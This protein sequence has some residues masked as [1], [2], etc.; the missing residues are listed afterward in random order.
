MAV[1]KLVDSTQLD[2]DLTSVANAIRTKGGTSA[3]LAFPADFVQAIEDIETGGGGD[4]VANDWLD[5]TKPV[6]E[7]SSDATNISYYTFNGHT[8]ITKVSVP[9]AT[10]IPNSCFKDCTLLEEVIAPNVTNVEGSA[11]KGTTAINKPLFFPKAYVWTD[12][13][14]GSSAPIIVCNRIINSNS[15][16]F[17]DNSSLMAVDFLGTA[18][19]NFNGNTLFANCSS[20]KTLILRDS[21]MLTLSNINSFDSTPFANGGSGGTL[22]VPQALI[23]EY[24]AATNWSTLLSYANNQILPIAVAHQL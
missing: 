21:T 2:A 19:Q 14:R 16:I 20:F 3:Q 13:F 24:Q 9:N 7:I 4:Y 22:Y 10:S 5:R 18:H 15:S 11:F 12:T 23:S 6:G 17:R 8:G 1:D